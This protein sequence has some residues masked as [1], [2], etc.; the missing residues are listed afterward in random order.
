MGRSGDDVSKAKR[1]TTPWRTRYL[2]RHP[3]VGIQKI[4]ARRFHDTEWFVSRGGVFQTRG[5]AKVINGVER[6]MLRSPDTGKWTWVPTRA[7]DV[8][9]NTL[10]EVVALRLQGVNIGEIPRSWW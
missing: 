8:I 9:C 5:K 10:A 6:R 2:Y 4:Y 7:S 1:T 3:M